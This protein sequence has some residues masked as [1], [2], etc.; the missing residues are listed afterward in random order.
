MQ[1][2]RLFSNVSLVLA[3]LATLLMIQPIAAQIAAK[4]DAT[5]AAFIRLD[6]DKDGFISKTEAVEM[7][8]LGA[9]FEDFD[10]NRDNKLDKEEFEKAYKKVLSRK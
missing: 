6:R 2:K 1:V 7:Q 8:G 3:A 9:V 10:E 4:E 5:S